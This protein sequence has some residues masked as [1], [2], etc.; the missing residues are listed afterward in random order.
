MPMRSSYSSES[1]VETAVYS[2]EPAKQPRVIPLSE[3]QTN[4]AAIASPIRSEDNSGSEKPKR[5]GWWA[6]VLED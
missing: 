4:P 5:K 6:R 3:A 2:A 1:R